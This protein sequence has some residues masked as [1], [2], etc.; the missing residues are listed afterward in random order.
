[1]SDLVGNPEDRFSHNE[2]HLPLWLCQKQYF[3]VDSH[4]AHFDSADSTGRGFSI[5]PHTKTGLII[6]KL[7]SIHI[8]EKLLMI[9]LSF[10]YAY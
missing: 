10:D 9:M 6:A 5:I 2:A 7:A 1:M 4:F 8:G 3:S